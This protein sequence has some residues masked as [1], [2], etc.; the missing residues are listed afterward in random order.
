MA[1]NSHAAAG[2]VSPQFLLQRRTS[3]SKSAG[4]AA[5]PVNG[6]IKEMFNNNWV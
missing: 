5:N 1:G 4:K 3:M 6:K 2:H